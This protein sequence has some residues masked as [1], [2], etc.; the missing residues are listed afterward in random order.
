MF[1]C[2]FIIHVNY[3][4]RRQELV[5][6]WKNDKLI[7]LKS[8]PTDM[9]NIWR[10][11]TTFCALKLIKFQITIMKNYVKYQAK[12][13]FLSSKYS[14]YTE[15]I[16]FLYWAKIHFLSSK[17]SL[18]SSKNPFFIEHL[19]RTQSKVDVLCLKTFFYPVLAIYQDVYGFNVY[20]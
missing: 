2:F 6:E 3:T 4:I 16:F 9:C 18:I 11:Q 12:M 14:F 1:F 5:I 17:N 15:Q 8:F 20:N 13:C 7:L 10:H 19:I